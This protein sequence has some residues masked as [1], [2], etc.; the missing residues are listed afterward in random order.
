MGDLIRLSV[1]SG[2]DHWTGLLDWITGLAHF[3]FYNAIHLHTLV[4][5]I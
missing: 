5:Y 2:L 4:G 1:I 3:L